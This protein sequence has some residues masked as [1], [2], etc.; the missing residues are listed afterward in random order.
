VVRLSAEEQ[1]ELWLYYPVNLQVAENVVKLESVWRRAAAAGYTH[2]LLTDSKFARLG[3]LG[4]KERFYFE[5]VARVK[6]LATELNLQLVPAVFHIGWSNNMLWHNPNLAEGLP[7]KDAPFWVRNGQAVPATDPAVRLGRPDW[8]DDSVTIEGATATVMDAARNARLVFNRTLPKFRCY[9]LS[10]RI[11]TED[12]SGTPEIKVLANGRSLQYQS[13]DV[14]RT[15]A[16]TRADVVFNTLDNENV[17]IYFGAWGGGKGLLVWQDWSI[18]EAGLV[19]VLRR[20]GTPLS[21]RGEDGRNFVEGKDFEPVADPMLGNVPYKGEY[22]SW[23][24]APAFRTRLPEGTRLHVSWYH[25]VIIYNGAVMVCVSEPQTD[26]LLQDEASRMR[27]AW[28]TRRY[29]MAHDEIR[30]LNW[31]EACADCGMDA[32]ALLA[33]QVRRCAGWL[34][35]QEVCVWSDMFDPYH[36]ARAGYYLVRGDLKGSWEGLDPSVTVVNW[37]F[38][39]RGESLNFFAGRGHR[40]VIAGYYDAPP[41]RVKLWLDSAARVKGVIGVMYTTWRDNYSDIEAFAKFCRQ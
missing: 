19:N 12:F 10:V 6:A 37:N 15:Q 16:L 9:H 14:R 26:A 17:A 28:G 13:L 34:Q 23:H 5:N 39:K 3:D 4:S 20:P 30:T 2:V 21:V 36:N 41:E 25:P 32:G 18:E 22:Q 35:G 27:A 38:D 11:K 40:Q 33:G 24:A 29:M 31:D 7:V 8:K 1:C